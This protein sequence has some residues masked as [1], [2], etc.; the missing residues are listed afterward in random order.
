MDAISFVMGEKKVRLRVTR[1][2]ELLHKTPTGKL[3]SQ[4]ARVTAVL[5]LE[6][7]SEMQF[8]RMIENSSTNHKINDQ[9]S[10][11]TLIF[12]SH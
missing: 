6:D 11:L 4:S 3:V 2:S 1:M 9:V 8:T 5:E 10:S 12:I 7:G